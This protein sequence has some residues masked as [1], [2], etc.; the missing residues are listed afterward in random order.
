MRKLRTILLIFLGVYL[1]L[2]TIAG[3]AIAEASLKLQHLPLNYRQQF[4][5]YVHQHYRT[6]FQEVSIQAT[7]SVVLK[8]WYVRQIDFNGN[9]VV[10]SHGITD[11]R[12]GVAGYARLFLNHGYAVLLPDTRAHGESGGELATYGVKEADDLHQWVSWL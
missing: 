10:L 2:A 12:E 11:N 3:V 8:G 9:T 1:V 4:A 5:R 6:D 7:D